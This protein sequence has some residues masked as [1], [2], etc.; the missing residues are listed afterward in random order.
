MLDQ[1][2][3]EPPEHKEHTENK[4]NA[5]L[6]KN[7][8]DNKKGVDHNKANNVLRKQEVPNSNNGHNKLIDCKTAQQQIDNKKGCDSRAK[9]HDYDRQISIRN[10]LAK[11]RQ[12]YLD[13][14]AGG[15]VE[16]SRRRIP[17]S[18]SNYQQL[19]EKDERNKT[20]EQSVSIFENVD[21]I[22]EII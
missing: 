19:P 1:K 21:K 18:R 9:Q 8:V 13:L 10:A 22:E 3:P 16:I 15:T 14:Q 4:E 12:K 17:S 11:T 2:P 20:A 6:V 5:T 7:S